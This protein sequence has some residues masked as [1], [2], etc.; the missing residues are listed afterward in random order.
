MGMIRVDKSRNKF[1]G[2]LPAPFTSSKVPQAP[3]CS[4]YDN[5]SKY[6]QK[7]HTNIKR[8]MERHIKLLLDSKGT[9]PAQTPHSQLYTFCYK[10]EKQ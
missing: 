2:Y 9:L 10:R 3:H 4:L 7:G 5:C 6:E 8:Q 1:P